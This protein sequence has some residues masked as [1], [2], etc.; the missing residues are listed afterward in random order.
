MIY[1]YE[2]LKGAAKV[3]I[4]KEDLKRMEEKV[5]VQLGFDFNFSSPRH[6]LDRYIRI[7]DE[8]L[9]EEYKTLALQILVLQQVTEKLL[10]Y[11]GSEIAASAVILAIN[12]GRMADMIERSSD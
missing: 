10:N 11:S 5:L 6:F 7:L 3:A 1:A 4:S 12:Q 8:H 2:E 9:P